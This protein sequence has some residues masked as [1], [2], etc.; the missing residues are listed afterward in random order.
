MENKYTK[1][2]TKYIQEAKLVSPLAFSAFTKEALHNH[3]DLTL[4]SVSIADIDKALQKFDQS[5]KKKLTIESVD[6]KLPNQLTGFESIFLDDKSNELLPHRIGH[7]MEIKI[8]KNENNNEKKLPYGP[9]YKMSKK[10]Y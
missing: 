6:K 4:A 5:Q 9:L 8:E 10:S 1:K 2:K 3:Q 7:D